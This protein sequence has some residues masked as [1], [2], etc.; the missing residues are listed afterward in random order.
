M[1]K[2]KRRSLQPSVH[3]WIPSLPWKAV[4]T[5]GEVKSFGKSEIPNTWN[6]GPMEYPGLEG[7]PKD[8]K[9]PTPPSACQKFR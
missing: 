6:H 5:A 9:N 2:G 1:E 8:D 4:G 7:T 3:P